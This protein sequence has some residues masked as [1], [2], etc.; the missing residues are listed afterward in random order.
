MV[1]LNNG[2]DNVV[3]AFKIPSTYNEYNDREVPETNNITLYHL[4]VVILCVPNVTLVLVASHSSMYNCPAGEID[5]AK[6]PIP[7]FP[8]PYI[9]D[10]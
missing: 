1:V 9:T 7:L 4:F 6:L 2:P 10:C 5:N 3:V 8:N